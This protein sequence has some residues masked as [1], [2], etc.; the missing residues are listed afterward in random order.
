MEFNLLLFGMFMHLAITCQSQNTNVRHLSMKVNRLSR[1]TDVLQKDVSDIWSVISSPGIESQESGNR[2]IT[3]INNIG[4]KDEGTLAELNGTL[5]EVKELKTEV[6]DLIVYSRSGFMNEKLFQREAIS[7]LKKSYRDFKTDLTEKNAEMKH[8]IDTNNRYLIEKVNENVKET[9]DHGIRFDSMNKMLE[10]LNAKQSRLEIENEE[11]KQKISDMQVELTKFQATAL[12]TC[13]YGWSRFHS[14]CYLFVSRKQ[15]WHNALATCES[16]DSYL[17]EVTTESELE[18]VGGLVNGNIIW[19][20]ATNILR[21]HE[22]DF[23]YQESQRAV[24]QTFWNDGEP[25]NHGGEEHCVEMFVRRGVAKF[26]DVPCT[27][28]WMVVCEKTVTQ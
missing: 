12:S 28:E 11:L 17:V 1:I 8:H 7:D 4:Q 14:N 15:T 27:F 2:I 25:N 18:F 3:D 5:N 26:N 16:K 13:D 10:N 19:I 24:H 20:G 23:V 21:G 6:E 9:E 22:G